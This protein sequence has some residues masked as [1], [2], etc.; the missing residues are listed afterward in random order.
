MNPEQLLFGESSNNSLGTVLA[1]K[2]KAASKAPTPSSSQQHHMAHSQKRPLRVE[3]LEGTAQEGGESTELPRAPTLRCGELAR[4]GEGCVLVRVPVDMLAL[5]W[6]GWSL[7]SIALQLKERICS[8]LEAIREE[9]QW[10]VYML[11]SLV[12]WI[13]SNLGRSWHHSD[14]Q[15][16]TPHSVS[17]H[18]FTLTSQDCPVTVAYPDVPLA[19]L[20]SP[21]PAQSLTNQ[22]LRPQQAKWSKFFGV[23]SKSSQ[24]R[25]LSR[26]PTGTGEGVVACHVICRHVVM[27]WF[28]NWT[29]LRHATYAVRGHKCWTP[30]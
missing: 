1:E 21:E 15:V 24:L 13:S 25:V 20:Q 17:L 10:K 19:P 11:L 9:I 7:R 4:G 16:D 6:W 5:V 30:T 22:E 28:Q 18:H 23:S 14:L 2:C 8:Q 27:F 26:H 29:G 3:V 12:Q